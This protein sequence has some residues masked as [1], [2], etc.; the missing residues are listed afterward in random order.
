MMGRATA[1]RGRRY[2]FFTDPG[3]GWLEVPRREVVASGVSISAYS[4]YDPVTDM[5]YLE[6][7]AD[8][9]AWLK[10]TGRDWSSLPVLEV[11]SSMS[12]RL[13]AYGP[14]AIAG[15]RVQA[16]EQGRER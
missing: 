1:G 7:D 10:A 9:W 2:R 12:R 14:E 16:V 4:Y 8:A 15:L 3:H 13:A 5:A 6:E 11:N